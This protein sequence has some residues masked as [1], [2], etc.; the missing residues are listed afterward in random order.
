MSQV[1]DTR[2]PKATTK[3]LPVVSPWSDGEP[4]KRPTFFAIVKAYISIARPDHWFKNVFMALGIVLAFF[5]HP[6]LINLASLGQLAFAVMITCLLA[7]SNYVINEILD[8]PTDLSHPVKRHRPIP[9][10]LVWLP[11]AYAEWLALGIMGLAL[12]WQVNTYF[13]ISG[14]FLLVMGMIYNIR[15]VRAKDL[16]YVDVLTESIN[17]PIRLLLGWFSINPTEFPPVSLLISYWMI[18]A[19]LMAAK[20]FA[21]YRSLANPEM[22]GAYRNSFRYYNEDKLLTSMFFYST[23]FALFLGIFIVRYKIELIVIMPLVPG[24]VSYYMYVAFKKGSPVQYPEKLYRESG[25]MLYLSICIVAFM[26]CMFVEIPGLY[27]FF[28]VPPPEF[29]PLWRLK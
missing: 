23:S 20:R 12:A 13:F 29:S 11:L 18:G 17:N 24:F 6:D 3:S 19:F 25:L 10:G 26:A 9:S 2:L 7:S 21:E 22:A 1:V 15:P 27:S 16:P 8:A 28:N 4:A 14:A 5:Y